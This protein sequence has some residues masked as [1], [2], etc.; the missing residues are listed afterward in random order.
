VTL[1]RLPKTAS[2]AIAALVVSG[3]A[4]LVPLVGPGSGGSASASAT[5]SPAAVSSPAAAATRSAA[6]GLAATSGAARTVLYLGDTPALRPR[7]GAQRSFACR[8]AVSLGLRCAV[9][10]RTQPPAALARVRADV[11]VL[12]LTSRDDG[13]AVAAALRRLPASLRTARTVVLAP[14][15]ATTTPAA[16]TRLTAVR[17]A[18][19]ARGAEVVDPVAEGWIPAAERRTYLTADGALTAAGVTRLTGLLADDLTRIMPS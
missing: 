19:E 15:A 16:A 9:R 18:A 13:G 2:A 10:S 4:A 8:A 1:S 11:V 12:V 7:G 3:T 14:V 17:R 5:P 6:S